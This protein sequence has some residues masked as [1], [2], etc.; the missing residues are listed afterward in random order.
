[1]QRTFVINIPH[2]NSVDCV[3]NFLKG[4]TSTDFIGDAM[5]NEYVQYYENGT[6]EESYSPVDIHLLNTTILVINM[7]NV[8]RFA[9]TWAYNDSKNARTQLSNG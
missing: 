8:T 1:M 3:T 5:S 4:A 2:N 9:W 7:S 6:V